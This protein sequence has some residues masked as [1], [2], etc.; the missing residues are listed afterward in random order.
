MFWAPKAGPKMRTTLWMAVL[1]LKLSFATY[2]VWNLTS[3]KQEVEWS[4]IA[5]P[6]D[7]NNNPDDD[8]DIGYI[9]IQDCEIAPNAITT[10]DITLPYCIHG[11]DSLT[12]NLQWISYDARVKYT[13]WNTQL[14]WNIPAWWTSNAVT[15]PSELLSWTSWGRF[16][17]EVETSDHPTGQDLEWTLFVTYKDDDG[18]D[19]NGA[20][21]IDCGSWNYPDIPDPCEENGIEVD[22]IGDLQRNASWWTIT[23]TAKFCEDDDEV[24]LECRISPSVTYS[25]NIWFACKLENGQS[26]PLSPLSWSGPV[27]VDFSAVGVNPLDIR[28]ISATF[29]AAQDTSW[30]WIPIEFQSWDFVELEIGWNVSTGTP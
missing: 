19:V 23:T 20:Q 9:A 12:F 11:Y 18:T 8:C 29:T 16:V 17:L 30:A 14:V 3:C 27:L 4:C 5:C 2:I 15:V 7:N 28:K 26:V 24:R 25:G 21:P 1:L 13:N 10:H 22:L 6:D